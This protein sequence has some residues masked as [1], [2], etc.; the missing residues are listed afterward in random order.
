MNDNIDHLLQVI[1]K[2]DEL[3]QKLVWSDKRVIPAGKG[4]SK[5]I[6]SPPYCRGC[7]NQKSQGHKKNCWI[8]R[9]ILEYDK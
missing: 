8:R 7:L 3:I 1:E 2:K 4:K 5:E 6:D 9:L